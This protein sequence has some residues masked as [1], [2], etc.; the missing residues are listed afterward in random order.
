MVL[1]FSHVNEQVQR[2]ALKKHYEELKRNSSG[3]KIASCQRFARVYYP[4]F[5]I[6]FIIAFWVLG[7]R[8]ASEEQF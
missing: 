5:C 4:G 2:E 7:L 1:I 8:N 3:T 6:V